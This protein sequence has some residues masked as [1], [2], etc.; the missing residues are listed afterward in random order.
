MCA[1]CFGYIPDDEET[2]EALDAELR[3]L[4]GLIDIDKR[5][6]D[7]WILCFQDR[8]TANAAQNVLDLYGVK[9]V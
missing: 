2:R 1:F 8:E 5:R 9:G 3:N 6:S 4:V 7:I